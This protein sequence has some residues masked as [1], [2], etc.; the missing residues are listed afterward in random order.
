MFF[1][2]RPLLIVI[3]C[4]IGV[5][6]GQ[7]SQPTAID[8]NLWALKDKI[9]SQIE[10]IKLAKTEAE[11]DME[12]ARLRM[13]EQLR[14]SEEKLALQIERL[15][16][17]QQ[18]M[19]GQLDET[20]QALS[21][22]NEELHGLVQSVA[23]QVNSHVDSVNSLIKRMRRTRKGISK[24]SASIGQGFNKPAKTGSKPQGAMK[25]IYLTPA[26]PK[27]K[28]SGPANSPGAPPDPQTGDKNCQ[29]DCQSKEQGTTK[30]TTVEKAPPQDPAPATHPS[31]APT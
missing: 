7:S 2:S 21:K 20:T 27:L 29:A 5:A 24:D 16:Q 22:A 9:E 3:V 17:Y 18:T 4:A 12:L 31:P 14:R 1:F 19:N 26:G 11:N 30:G 8:A 13:G 28:E 10:K 15:N 25:Q 6:H 23:S